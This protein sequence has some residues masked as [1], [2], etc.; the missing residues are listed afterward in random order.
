MKLHHSLT[1]GIGGMQLL[2]TLFDTDAEAPPLRARSPP[3]PTETARGTAELVTASLRPRRAQARSAWPDTRRPR[4]SPR[5]GGAGGTP[6]DS[7][8]DAVET[9][10]SVGRTVAPVSHTL[11]P[12]MKG[13]SLGRRLAMLE[14]GLDDLKQA[15]AAAGGSVNDGFMAAVTGGF[16]RYHEHHGQPVDELRVT[17][18]ISTRTPEDP[19]GGNRIT[20]ERFTVPVGLRDPAAR[21]RAIGERCRA[22]RDERSIP[23]SNTIAGALNLLPP[24]AVGSDAQARRLPGEQRAGPRVPRLPGRRP[25][26]A[27]RPVRPDHRSGGQRH[28]ALLRR[29]LRGRSHGRHRG[30]ARHRRVHGC[31]AE[32]FEEVLAL[33]GS[34]PAVAR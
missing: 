13:R 11:S 4:R 10:R 14:V 31:L 6:C 20:L 27:V 26:D 2:L 23:Y 7:A 9:I 29:H 28:P 33:A 17:L 30:G 18:P 16:R 34:E 24:G 19:A 5:R 32:G 21:I 1:D 22:A 12:V 25:D 15:S 8:R 3:S